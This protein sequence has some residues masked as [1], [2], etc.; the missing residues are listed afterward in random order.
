MQSTSHAIFVGLIYD[1][2][3]GSEIESGEGKKKQENSE[4]KAI[5][6]QTID[7]KID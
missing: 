5:Y 2:I 3:H 1:V 6:E 7:G 4:I